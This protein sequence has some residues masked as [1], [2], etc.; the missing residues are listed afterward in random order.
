MPSECDVKR[1]GVGLLRRLKVLALLVGFV[2]IPTQVAA[3][4][5]SQPPD[6]FVSV[7]LKV[8]T[9]DRSVKDRPTEEL[10]I[11]VVS[12]PADSGIATAA[13]A[14]LAELARYRGQKILGRTIRA[15]SR[16]TAELLAQ[17]DR[18]VDVICLTAE[19]DV[20]LPNILA[21]SRR[22]RA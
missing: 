10:L 3:Q 2:L 9:F 14:L 18:M 16:T 1:R 21:W 6:A 15:E 20:A 5:I 7:L 8:L 22:N 11:V 12:D 19:I 13:D 4:G 17:D